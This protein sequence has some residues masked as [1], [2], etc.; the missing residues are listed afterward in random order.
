MA[1]MESILL[2]LLVA[3]LVWL[4]MRQR[5]VPPSAARPVEPSAHSGK[6]MP[7]IGTP[8]TATRAQLERLRAFHFEPSSHWSREEA[9]LILDT[10]VYLR[11][12]IEQVTGE[13][14]P[15]E[16]LQNQVLVF[17][18]SD[19]ALR[20]HLLRWGEERRRKTLAQLK[21]P[22]VRDEHFERVAEF[23]RKAS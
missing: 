23:I 13:R 14:Q 20:G 11:A 8:G 9:Q 7:R 18:L 1:G 12:A 2:G 15:T 22:P 3:L 4:V 10:V 19:E 16:A 6:T 17:I 5:R 21:A